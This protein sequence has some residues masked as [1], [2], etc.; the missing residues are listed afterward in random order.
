MARTAD[1]VVIG[2]GVMG[3]SIAFHLAARGL[4]PLVLEQNGV[5]SASTSRSAAFVRMHYTN[6]PEARLAHF[7]FPYFAGWADRVG[8]DCHF[9]RTGFLCLV[10]PADGDK[11]RRNVAMLQGVG[12]DTDVLEPAAVGELQP[13]LSTDGIGPAA[14]EAKSGYADPVATTRALLRRAQERGA[15][16]EEGTRVE[17][18]RVEGGRVR[19][20]ATQTDRIDSPVVVSAAG[21]WSQPL[22]QTAEVAVDIKPTRAQI[23]FFAR[24]AEL[25][26]GHVM[27]IDAAQGVYARPHGQDL[28]LAGIGTWRTEL[29]DPTQYREENDP[30]F[31]DLALKTLGIRFPAV[32]GQPYRRGHAGLYDMSPDTRAILDQVPSGSGLFLATGF[33]GTGFKISPAVGAG[34]AEWITEGATQSVDLHPFRLARFAE[35]ALIGGPD[36]YEVPAHFGHRL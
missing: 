9:T 8:Y 18:I 17:T 7:S 33:S 14:Y 19:G 23:A 32:L 3:A 10:R 11:L 22:L 34:L 26:T 4:R 20:V 36:E 29:A 13:H 6:E 2:A 16:L 1:A 35:G 5:A 21:C 27:L 31:V 15:R 12:I 30:E 24:P 28:T 25:K